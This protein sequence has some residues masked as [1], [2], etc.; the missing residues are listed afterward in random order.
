MK[1]TLSLLFLD[2]DA[3]YRIYITVT[4]NESNMSPTRFS[5]SVF[6]PYLQY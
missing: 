6:M 1:P 4:V 3:S 2:V 5:P